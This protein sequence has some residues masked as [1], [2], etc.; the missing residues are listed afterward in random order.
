MMMSK[1]K[2]D[3]PTPKLT[4]RLTRLYTLVEFTLQLAVDFT[5]VKK[6]NNQVFKNWVV[7]G[8]RTSLHQLHLCHSESINVHSDFI[9]FNLQHKG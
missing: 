3:C 5:Q 1:Q 2:D 4:L 9:K 6:T 7:A 8:L